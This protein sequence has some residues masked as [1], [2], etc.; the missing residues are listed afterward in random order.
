MQSYSQARLF[1][2][3]SFWVWF[4]SA[5]CCVRNLHS[6]KIFL[7]W[8]QLRPL[9]WLCPAYLLLARHTAPR[10]WWPTGWKF[11]SASLISK[12][13]ILTPAPWSELA[14]FHLWH[15]S[16]VTSTSPG[17]GCMP[18]LLLCMVSGS[19]ALLLCPARCAF[20]SIVQWDVMRPPALEWLTATL[21][22]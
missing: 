10:T 11:K 17:L 2:P 5:C 21:L 3:P 8:E 22:S 20:N 14:V 19:P 18:S 6:W 16:V 13:L 7:I 15:N 9:V 12:A 4:S 1:P